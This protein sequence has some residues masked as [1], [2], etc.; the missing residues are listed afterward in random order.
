DWAARRMKAMR[1]H[2]IALPGRVVRH[3]RRLIVRLS[4]GALDLIRDARAAILSLQP[5]RADDRPA[6]SAS[7]ANAA[8]L[9]RPRRSRDRRIGAGLVNDAGGRSPTTIARACSSRTRLDPRPR[10]KSVRSTARFARAHELDA[11]SL[12]CPQLRVHDP[13][14]AR[15]PSNLDTQCLFGTEPAIAPG[16]APLKGLGSRKEAPAA[17]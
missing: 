1:F 11:G 16:I 12:D 8:G 6:S 10:P 13:E 4:A 9:G 5:G 3:A 15:T 7:P 14:L 2:L 17:P